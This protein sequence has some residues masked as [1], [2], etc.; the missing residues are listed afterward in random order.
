MPIRAI[1]LDLDDT[2]WPF[3]PVAV[4]VQAALAAWMAE[5]APATAARFGPEAAR[6]TFLA[7]REQRPDLAHRI[8]DIRR[9]ALRRML[10]S[11]GEDPALADAAV[12]VTTEVRQRIDLYPEVPAALDRLAAHVP[13]LAVTNGNA[14]LERTGVARWFTGIV[15]AGEAGV[16]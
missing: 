6:E 15:S 3:A 2:L 12:V 5:H 7:V 13:L 4:R 11:A 9:E 1:T 8:A 16:A 14:E 10:A